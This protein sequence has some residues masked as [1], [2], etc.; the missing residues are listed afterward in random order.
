MPH[1]QSR[2]SRSSQQSTSQWWLAAVL[3]FLVLL[4]Y[5]PAMTAG[6]I[7]DDDHYVTENDEL[8]SADG[9][10]RIWFKP[11]ATPQ[12]YPLVFSTFWVEHQLWGIN[13]V[14]YH[15]VNIVLHGL[16]AVLLL[17]ALQVLRV[18]GALFAA[19]LFAVAPLHVES[20]AW[21]SER[22]NVLSGLFY[23][24]AFLSYWRFV[25]RSEESDTTSPTHRWGAYVFSLVMFGCALMS[26]SVTCSLPAAILLVFWWKQGRLTFRNVIPLLPMFAIGV[27]AGVHTILMEK[28]HV[29]AQG[30]DWEWSLIER[31]LIASRAVWFYAAKLVWPHPLVFVYP[32]WQIDASSWWQ[33]AFGMLALG[34]VVALWLSRWRLGRG[35]LVAVLFFVGTLFPALGFIDVYPMRFSFVA[36]HFAYLA[37]IGLIALIAAAAATMSK[38]MRVPQRWSVLGAAMVVMLFSTISFIRCFDYKDAETLWVATLAEN[39]RCWMASFNLAA[40]RFEQQRYAEAGALFKNALRHEQYDQPSYDEQ[41]DLHLYLGDTLLVLGR[42]Q[43]SKEH[44]QQAAEYYERVALAETKNAEPYN[45]LGILYG[46]LEQSDQAIRHFQQALEIDPSDPDVNLNLGELYY[47]LKRFDESVECFQRVLEADSLNVRAHYNLGTVSLTTGQREEAIHHLRA[48]LKIA[49]DFAAAQ[50]VLQQAMA[51]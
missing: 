46:K 21:V 35:P 20:V 29:G 12:Y 31:F 47:R 6:F 41:A 18:P 48:A 33:Y 7:W 37:S 16:N 23:L 34:L 15:L 13:P 17:R 40:I 25:R 28:H 22:K 44:F 24:L 11:G 42:P 32:K 39:P 38:R 49:P 43:E 27:A 14:G 8:R 36:D 50:I 26:K 1:P 45:N 2:P 5:A 3:L 30:V 51:M 19:A 10:R 4:T 9:L